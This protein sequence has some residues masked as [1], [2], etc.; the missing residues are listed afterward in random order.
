MN[1]NEHSST[2]KS[3][4]R[5]RV[6]GCALSA[7]VGWFALNAFL[8]FWAFFTRAEHH[9]NPPIPNEW[10]VGVAFIAAYSAAFIF[11][12]WLVALLP[13]YLFVPQ[14]SFLWRWPVCTICG[15]AAGGLIMFGFYGP[16]STDSFSNVAII[17][18][19]IVGGITCL[20][21]ALTADRFHHP[22]STATV[23]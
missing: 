12:T 4:L 23:A 19:S 5:R 22:P 1:G 17:L 13:L 15:A 7:F 14:L 9:S 11:A 18:A 2:A 3:P 8:L 16:N 10:L 6:F 20:F 21:A